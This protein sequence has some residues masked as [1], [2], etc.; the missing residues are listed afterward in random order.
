MEAAL[1]RLLIS[2]H[3]PGPGQSGSAG[4]RPSF[5]GASVP[6]CPSGDLPH[7]HRLPLE[8]A[9]GPSGKRRFN[10]SCSEASHSHRDIQDGWW[11]V[12]RGSCSPGRNLRQKD[13]RVPGRRFLAGLEHL[14]ASISARPGRP[15]GRD[16]AQGLPGSVPQLRSCTF[17]LSYPFPFACYEAFRVFYSLPKSSRKILGNF[18]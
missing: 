18:A 12:G 3:V 15:S 7:T 11:L 2:T 6:L 1:S 14:P 4:L 5:P 13:P 8:H 9:L 10:Y 16:L 17:T